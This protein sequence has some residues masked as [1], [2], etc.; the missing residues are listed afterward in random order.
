MK[1]KIIIVA[2][3]LTVF[4]SGILNT[5]DLINTDNKNFAINT[6]TRDTINT[7]LLSNT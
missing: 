4:L 6:I 1:N 7:N 2:L 3:S 5:T